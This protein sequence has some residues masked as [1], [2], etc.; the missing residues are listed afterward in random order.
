MAPA[1]APAPLTS[2]NKALAPAT[3]SSK[4]P[5]SLAPSS[6]SHALPIKA[7]VPDLFV[8]T[9]PLKKVSFLWAPTVLDS[10]KRSF[11]Y[12]GYQYSKSQE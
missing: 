7:V 11:L 2:E 4:N 8:V 3:A 1:P 9:D 6:G 12:F 5:S 10:I